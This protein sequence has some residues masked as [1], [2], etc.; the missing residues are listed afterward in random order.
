MAIL[1][2]ILWG[3]NFFFLIYE[4]KIEN[5]SS[6]ARPKFY[7]ASFASHKCVGASF[8]SSR[9]PQPLGWHH[10]RKAIAKIPGLKLLRCYYEKRNQ[11]NDILPIRTHLPALARE[12]RRQ[13]RALS[14]GR[15]RF[16]GDRN[17]RTESLSKNAPEPL[18]LPPSPPT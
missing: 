7:V 1:N 4:K 15:H 13:V 6:E 3:S 10:N 8:A 11:R 12:N 2:V 9:A 5:R 17:Q 14:F 16:S 18:P